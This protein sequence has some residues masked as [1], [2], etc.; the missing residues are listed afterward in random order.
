MRYVQLGGKPR[1][2]LFFNPLIGH[3]F[4]GKSLVYHVLHRGGQF[5]LFGICS[6]GFEERGLEA[7]V[8]FIY[9]DCKVPKNNFRLGFMLRVSESTN[10]I[11]T[12]LQ[13]LRQ[14]TPHFK[15]TA[16]I[17]IN[18]IRQLPT[19]DFFLCSTRGCEFTSRTLEPHPHNFD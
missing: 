4:A 16:E 10:I 15:S 2:H 8:T 18:K 3:I 11:G 17:V 5:H 14:V 12:I 13:C 1:Q 7:M 9:L 6:M 19:Q